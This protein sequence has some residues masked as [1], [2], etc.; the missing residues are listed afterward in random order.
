[1]TKSRKVRTISCLLIGMLMGIVASGTAWAENAV[2]NPGFEQSAGNWPA[3]W[4][5]R[6]GGHWTYVGDVSHS[7]SKSLK[8]TYTSSSTYDLVGQPGISVT[9]GKSYLVGAW[10]KTQ[11][12]TGPGASIF[13]EWLHNSEWLGGEWGFPKI[14]GI[15]EWKFIS[16]PSVLAPETANKAILYLE[17]ARGSTGTAW[18]DDII[19]DNSLAPLLSSFIL[20]PNYAGKILPGAPSPEIEVEITLNPGGYG[21]TLDQLNVTATLKDQIGDT[22]VQKNLNSLSSDTFTV[23][24]DIP[25]STPAGKYALTI[26]LS[27][28]TG[29][30]LSQNAY[31]LDKLSNERFSHLTSYIDSDNRFI[32]NGEPFFPIGIYMGDDY[33]VNYTRVDEVADSPFDT[34]MNYAVNVGNPQQIASYLDYLHSKNLNLI[35]SLKDY[36]G[37]GQADLDTITQKVNAYQGYPAVISWYMNDEKGLS[38]LPELEARYQKVRELDENHPVWSVH[39]QKGDLIGEAHTTDILG[40]DPYPIPS[41]PITLVSQM[42]DWAKEAGRGY[43]PLWLVPQ[44]FDQSNYGRPGR[45]PTPEEMRAMTYLATNHGA[46][47]LIYYSY[48]D[49]RSKDYYETQWAAVKKIASEIKTLRQV[50]LS[51]QKAADNDITCDNSSIDYKL[52]KMDTQYYLFAV[53]TLDENITSVSFQNNLTYKPSVISVLFENG[54]QITA[55][56]GHFSDNFLPYEVHVYELA[57]PTLIELGQFTAVP[58]PKEKKIIITFRTLS[59]I[60]TAGFNL[61]RSNQENGEYKKI[62]PRLIESTGNATE[63]GEYSYTDDKVRFGVTYYYKLEEIDNNGRS[64]FYGP[65]SAVFVRSSR[66]LSH[67]SEAALV[68]PCQDYFFIPYWLSTYTPTPWLSPWLPPCCVLDSLFCQGVYSR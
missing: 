5:W 16:L 2:P 63:G 19:V 45:L 50:F 68:E 53:N 30:L 59:E 65:V 34:I 15:N 55:S 12:V 28:K 24:L 66:V 62:N 49:I 29:D 20:R 23:S 39:F 13:I 11:N 61:W 35:Y 25:E 37:N 14:T 27:A 43:R 51:T 40:V 47:G 32:L 52:M 9:G 26:D 36:I 18:Y 46:K 44:I 1:M 31:S 10:I 64:T 54:R 6:G 48:F 42:A 33:R 22:I 67:S 8:V 4:P 38:Y 3:S 57:T 60:D 7:G 41:S 56:N 17:L 21:L 58:F